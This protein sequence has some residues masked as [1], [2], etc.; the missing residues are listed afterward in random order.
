VAETFVTESG[1]G[2][3]PKRVFAAG[4]KIARGRATVSQNG[5]PL[6]EWLE[7]VVCGVLPPFFQGQEN[8]LSIYL[9]RI[10]VVSAATGGSYRRALIN[11]PPY[12]SPLL[13][14]CE[15]VIVLL[16][17]VYSLSPFWSDTSRSR[18]PPL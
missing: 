9:Q 3:D 7:R 5:I 2:R 4:A 11:P 12:S 16:V 1:N 18:H 15:S 14:T 10:L 17:S 8:F 13:S 6:N